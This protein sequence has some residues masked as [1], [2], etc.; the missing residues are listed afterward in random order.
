MNPYLLTFGG[1][2][3]LNTIKGVVTA[4]AIGEILAFC[5]AVKLMGLGTTLLVMFGT[6]VLG[7]ALL[8]RIGLEAAREF[9]RSAMMGGGSNAGF[10]DG[11]LAA[12]GALLLILPGFVSDAMGL[13]LSTPSIRQAVAGRF[14][15]AGTARPGPGPAPRRAAQDVID[16]A[17]EDWR[18]VD[19]RGQA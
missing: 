5:L 4:W 17:P 18:V 8:R 16:L 6:S 2:W 13:A 15:I 9:R 3:S 19:K 1:R 10:V 12:F 7:I 11:T 14:L